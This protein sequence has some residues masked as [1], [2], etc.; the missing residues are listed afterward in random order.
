[1]DRKKKRREIT[2][3]DGNSSWDEWLS[4]TRED[5]VWRVAR[6]CRHDEGHVNQPPP[7]GHGTTWV[8]D[9]DDTS[10]E[11]HIIALTDHHLSNLSHVS[12]IALWAVAQP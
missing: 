12:S 11:Y 8:T 4:L 5:V 2:G 3:W 7:H 10:T 9:E 1:L 6:R